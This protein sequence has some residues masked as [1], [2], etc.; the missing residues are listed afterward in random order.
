MVGALVGHR[1]TD[2]A[3]VEC[4][5]L[6]E[7]VGISAD[8]PG[9]LRHWLRI[10]FAEKVHPGAIYYL[11]S[12]A[13]E[14]DAV[15]RDYASSLFSAPVDIA[16][17]G[18]GENG[19]IAFNDPHVADF[20]DPLLIKRVFT[21]EAAR[22]QQVGEGHFPDLKSVPPEAVTVTCSGLFRAENWICCVPDARKA[23]AVK[24]ALEGP[25]TTR[26]PASL[27]RRHPR[28]FVYLDR[29]SAALLSPGISGAQSGSDRLRG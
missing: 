25:I 23:K 22:L 18:F 4:F 15:I 26:C 13:K 10:R 12:D 2:W 21:D 8:H 7:Y 16:F 3:K 1:K 29:P 17:I 11:Q 14:L 27:V 20:D 28:A 5:H 24:A 19:H 9:S 6:D